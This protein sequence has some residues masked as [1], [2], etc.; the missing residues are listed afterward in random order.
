MKRYVVLRSLD[1]ANF[2]PHTPGIHQKPATGQVQYFRL[3]P[4][5]RR[6]VALKKGLTPKFP[7]VLY[8]PIKMSVLFNR[9]CVWISSYIASVLP[10]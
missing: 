9:V 6:F 1:C 8:C 10:A 4:F 7:T 3:S 2:L 5:N